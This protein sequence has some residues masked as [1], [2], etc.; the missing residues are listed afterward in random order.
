MC[1]KSYQNQIF[2]FKMIHFD[3]YQIDPQ[4]PKF[5]TLY[6]IFDKTSILFPNRRFE[7][8]M[9]LTVLESKKAAN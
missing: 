2:V 8:V 3:I 4:N 9:S 5:R 6:S 7:K 1:V